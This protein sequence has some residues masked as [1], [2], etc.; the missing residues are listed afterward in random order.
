MSPGASPGRST[1]TGALSTTISAP[2]SRTTHLAVLGIN[3]ARSLTFKDGRISH[4][5]MALIRE[6][7]RDGAE[8]EDPDPRHPPSPVRDADRRGGRADRSGRPPR[9]GAG[10]GRRRR[11][12]YHARRPFPPQLHRERAADGREA[13]AAL[14]IQAGTATST[15]LR[16]GEMQS[17]NLIHAERND[18]VEVQVIAWDGAAFQRRQPA[19]LR[20]RRR[21]LG[22]RSRP[23]RSPSPSTS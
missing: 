8:G 4:E 5:Q 9:R 7:F 15:R 20:L 16:H 10:G 11:R 18:R 23:S 22:S 14:V 3:T 17:F 12:P 1:A 2:G 13:G 19:G 21:E 6:R